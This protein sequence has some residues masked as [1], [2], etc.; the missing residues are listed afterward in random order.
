MRLMVH[1]LIA[2]P[3]LAKP[4]RLIDSAALWLLVTLFSLWSLAAQAQ[5]DSAAGAEQAS[6]D[7]GDRID[8]S[9]VEVV[10]V[11]GQRTDYNA[12]SASSGTRFE[13]DL[14]DVPVSVQVVPRS[15][16]EDQGAIQIGEALRNVSGVTVGDSSGN[17]VEKFLVRGFENDRRIAVDG[18]LPPTAFG[19]VGYLDLAMVEQVEVLKG[20]ASVLY[21][22]ANP[23][24]FINLVSK[25]P[26]DAA[27]YRAS[28]AT[29][30]EE[31][32]RAELDI[33]QP[34]SADNR[35]KSRFVFAYQSADSFRDLFRDTERLLLA[36]SFS[37]QV[38]ERSSVDL[39]IEYFDRSGP[40]DFGLLPLNG[41]ADTL[42]SEW[43]EG[44]AF[45]QVDSELLQG[46]LTYQYRFENGWL[47]KTALRASEA[48]SNRF[49]ADARGI[50]DDGRTVRRRTRLFP[51]DVEDLTSQSTLTGSF[52][53]GGFTHDF[54]VGVDLSR[55]DYDASDR[56]AS[57]ASIDA[58][59]PVYGAMPGALDD[60]RFTTR[61]VDF[62]AVYFQDLVSMGEHW[63][64]LLGGRFDHVEQRETR[65]DDVT[66]DVEDR[67]FSP[68]VGVVYKPRSD[69]SLYASYTE[70]FFPPPAL[71]NPDSLA[72]DEPFEPERG[73]QYEVG[74]KTS[75]LEERFFATMALFELTR[76][77]V[78]TADPFDPDLSVQTGEQ[79]S[80]GVEVDLR[81]TL[82]PNL[83]IV[84]TYTY[85]DA[86][87]TEDNVFA[88]GNRLPNTSEHS[89]SLW[90][91]FNVDRGALNGLELGAGAYAQS[92]RK[93]NLANSYAVDS[94]VRL[95]AYAS[96]PLTPKVAVSLNVKNLLDEDYIAAALGNSINPG[97]PRTLLARL[98]LRF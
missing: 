56:R 76:E 22:Q 83:N 20:P 21:G 33:N 15:L 62:A 34:L 36:P 32:Y 43:Y 14:I 70:S 98:D 4:P 9:S 35:L 95:D 8:E 11:L 80:R 93:G 50:Q 88:V 69:L 54:L 81:G 23:G 2:S 66:N 67:E 53:T 44:E 84:A 48:Q 39:Q 19:N 91:M 63:K 38:N 3:V 73:I 30:S 41:E 60:P 96:Y 25:R 87:I 74:V 7:A 49:S 31:F 65:N 6:T 59:D 72:N 46:R 92:S 86:E 55:S 1:P 85:L 75:L 78:L 5:G 82:L 57:L 16:F 94:F 52:V 26:Q 45:S 13:V 17:R 24:G 40:S 89:G 68:R 18:F 97:E 51:Q 28:L 27:F 12:R 29:G 61:S 90:A 71:F 58:F 42:D 79:R 37:W 10:E 47:F 77:N 64:V